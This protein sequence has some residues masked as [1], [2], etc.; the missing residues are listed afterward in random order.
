MTTDAQLQP[1]TRSLSPGN[2]RRLLFFLVPV[3][4]QVLAWDR[5]AGA[6]TTP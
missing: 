2:V 5:S 4:V 6:G 3:P 1:N